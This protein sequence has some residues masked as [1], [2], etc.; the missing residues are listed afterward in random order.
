MSPKGYYH[1]SYED[2][3]QI[4][5]LMRSGTSYSSIAKHL[6]VHQSNNQQRIKTQQGKEGVSL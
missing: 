1:L 3:C 5:A 2:R 6:S 4:Y